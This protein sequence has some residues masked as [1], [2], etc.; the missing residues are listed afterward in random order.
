M[1]ASA[2]ASNRVK[3]MGAEQCFCGSE[4]G[5]GLMALGRRKGVFPFILYT[6][7]LFDV[8]YSLEARQSPGT[9]GPCR[10]PAERPAP[11]T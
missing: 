6:S 4:K 7:L 11:P 1:S 3:L 5:V 10:S 8:S 9:E 2:L